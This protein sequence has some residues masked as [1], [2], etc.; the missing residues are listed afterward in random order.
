[1]YKK[2]GIAIALTFTTIL[3]SC[4]SKPSENQTASNSQRIISI[5]G[6]VTETIFELGSDSLIVGLDVTSTY[7]PHLAEVPRIGHVRQLSAEKLL[8][9][10]PDLVLDGAGMEP[11]VQK[12][13]EEAGVKVVSLPLAMDPESAF[14]QMRIIGENL[15][16]K[17]AAEELITSCKEKLASLENLKSQAEEQPR[18][19]FIYSRGQ[20]NLSVAGNGTQAGAMIELAGGINPLKNEFEGFRP[21]S[22]E[23]L[24]QAA[25]DILFLFTDAF[26][27]MGGMDG[28]LAVPG[29]A[30]TPAGKNHRV[31]HLDGHYA[32]GFGPRF[33]DAATDL[34][35]LFQ[36]K[37]TP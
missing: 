26:E 16:Q 27:A 35:L 23:A 14:E 7:P 11:E 36:A 32:T 24:V 25:P 6:S 9:L 18:V 4:N 15:N 37:P 13:L 10:N 1:M 30:E 28:L 20:G 31:I 3:L 5:G 29:V 8:G 34:H 33:A 22:A 17:D 19:V 12:Q 2:A 21:L